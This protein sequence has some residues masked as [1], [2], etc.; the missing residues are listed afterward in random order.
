M[1]FSNEDWENVEN[2]LLTTPHCPLVTERITNDTCDESIQY[3]GEPRF[4]PQTYQ[5]GAGSAWLG[6]G[7]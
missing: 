4:W 6:Y 2:H 7:V 1:K 3:S 5:D